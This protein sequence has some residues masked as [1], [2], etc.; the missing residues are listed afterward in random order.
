MNQRY[1]PLDTINTSNVKQLK[2][3]WRTHLR[4]RAL[5]AKYSGESQPVV[6][7]GAIYVTTGDDDVFAVSAKTGKILWKYRGQPARRSRRSAAA[8]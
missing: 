8:G 3:V 7:K 5:A 4:G 6:Y 2:G 1:S